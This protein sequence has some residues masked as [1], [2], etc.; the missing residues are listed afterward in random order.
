[1]RVA[2]EITVAIS[3]RFD[4]GR[5]LATLHD[6]PDGAVLTRLIGNIFQGSFGLRKYWRTIGSVEVHVNG[7]IVAASFPGWGSLC[8]SSATT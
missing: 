8:S 4:F 7:H 5:D 2:T 1:M 6:V 3:S